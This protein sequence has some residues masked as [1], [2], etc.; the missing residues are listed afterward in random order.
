MRNDTEWS[1][2]MHA[3]AEK[4]AHMEQQVIHKPKRNKKKTKNIAGILV[5]V[6]LELCVSDF[7]GTSENGFGIARK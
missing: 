3:Q 7:T 2:I 1:E 5:K 6:H 4:Q